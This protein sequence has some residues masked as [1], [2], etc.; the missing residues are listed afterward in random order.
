MSALHHKNNYDNNVLIAN[1][2][3]FIFLMEMN[4]NQDI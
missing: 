4:G 1:V 3:V 2:M